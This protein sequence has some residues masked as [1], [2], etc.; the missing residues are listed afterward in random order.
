MRQSPALGKGFSLGTLDELEVGRAICRIYVIGN[1]G[2]RREG[3]IQN[4]VTTVLDLFV[5]INSICPLTTRALP[6]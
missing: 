2:A 3:L 4:W 1:T 6:N 5:N